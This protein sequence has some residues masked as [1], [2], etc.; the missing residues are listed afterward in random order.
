MEPW[1]IQEKIVA[2]LESSL[3]E[4]ITV[5]QNV[6][7]PCLDDPE[8]KRQIDVLIEKASGPAALANYRL[9]RT[10][11]EVQKRSGSV[12]IG[13]FDG[14]LEKMKSVGAQHLI[15]VSE[16]PFPKSVKT[17]AS[18]IGPSVIL[19]TLKD[20]DQSNTVFAPFLSS[21]EVINI[22]YDRLLRVQFEG[23]H[24]FRVDP[25]KKM[26]DPSAQPDPHDK[27]FRL[28][29]GTPVSAG[30]LF[31]MHLFGG[32]DR[33]TKFRQDE[34][35]TVEVNFS[36]LPWEGNGSVSYRDFGG[37]WVPLK[38]LRVAMQLTATRL[39]C[40]WSFA[41]YQHIEGP[42]AGWIMKAQSTHDDG[43]TLNFAATLI[44][45]KPGQYFIKKTM[46]LSDADVFFQIGNKGFR[47]APATVFD[48]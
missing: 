24:L 40:D 18:R 20:I 29:N 45:E 15:C 8:S 32:E 16:K 21:T 43:R 12:E 23:H 14:W 48:H 38:M 5:K 13:H 46:S 47:S 34:P 31:D 28:H 10:I 2:L 35:I 6:F 44:E 26:V 7:L 11:V 27:C 37:K 19:M 4:D 41:E 39:E 9:T 1:K 36:P 25:K 33:T 30:D 22:C 3:S 17:K 42:T